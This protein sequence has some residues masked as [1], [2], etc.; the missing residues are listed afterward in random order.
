MYHSSSGFI[1]PTKMATSVHHRLCVS[2]MLLPPFEHTSGCVQTLI[3]WGIRT[4]ESVLRRMT[5]LRLNQVLLA[6]PLD[7]THTSLSLNEVSRCIKG[8]SFVVLSTDSQFVT[9][10]K[11]WR[12]ISQHCRDRIRGNGERGTTEVS[13]SPGFG[14]TSGWCSVVRVSFPVRINQSY[15]WKCLLSTKVTSLRSELYTF[16]HCHYVACTKLSRPCCCSMPPARRGS[17]GLLV[18]YGRQVVGEL[19][20]VVLE[21]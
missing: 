6:W 13:P 14:C 2:S 19:L 3:G 12:G 17:V 11:W 20:G 9:H 18:S 16:G 21:W 15:R 10:G 1:T 7:G 4:P 5:H 8:I